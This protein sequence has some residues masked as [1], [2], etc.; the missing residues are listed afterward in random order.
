MTR[1]SDA[2][3]L[4]QALG[5]LLAGKL[6]SAINTA[7]VLQRRGSASAA[8]LESLLA[9]LRVV[10]DRLDDLLML[11]SAHTRFAAGD[12][13]LEDRVRTREDAT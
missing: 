2:A 1:R 5:H 13:V 8:E 3:R 11:G 7:F 6:Q 12:A 4:L 10:R 9:D